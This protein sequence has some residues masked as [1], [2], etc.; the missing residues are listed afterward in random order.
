MEK[1]SPW[2]GDGVFKLKEVWSY[3]LKNDLQVHPQES[4]KENENSDINTYFPVLV[5]TVIATVRGRQGR[6]FHVE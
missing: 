3:A 6:H 5:L 4:L 1:T 2:I